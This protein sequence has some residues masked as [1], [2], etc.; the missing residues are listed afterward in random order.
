MY[1][2]LIFAVVLSACSWSA[3]QSDAIPVDRLSA[4]TPPAAS[5]ATPLTS[6]ARSDDTVLAPPACLAH[7]EFPPLLAGLRYGVNAFLFGTRQERVVSL[8]RGAGF[9]WLRQQ[10]HWRD[11]EIAPGR[12][13]WSALDQ[14]VTAARSAGVDVLLSVVR[15]PRW[16]TASGAG[17]LPDDPETFAPFLRALAT[18]YAGQ[19]GAYEIWNEPNLAIENGGVASSPAHYLDTLSTL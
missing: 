16:A 5:L 4:A 11:I 14:V 8:V 12:Y 19:V 7:G 13:D 17:G 15:S 3:T 2:I 9:T 6:T 10:I 1:R 18:R